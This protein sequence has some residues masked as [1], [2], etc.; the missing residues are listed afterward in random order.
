MTNRH[1]RP[2]RRRPLLPLLAAT[3][4]VALAPLAAQAQA[5][6]GS[7]K[8]ASEARTLPEFHA[9]AQAGSIDL[10]V[11][12][13]GTQQVTVSADDNLL[14]Y[15]ETVVES[16]KDGAMLQIRWKRGTT[17]Y[18]RSRVGVQV[19]V[20]R[21]TALRSAGSGD[22]VVEAFETPALELA[23]SG[24]GDVRLQGLRTDELN[25]RI[26]GSSDVAGSGSAKKLGITIAGSGDVNLGELKADEVKVRIAGSGDAIVHA[27]QTLDVSVAG[28][29][30]VRY[31]GNAKVKSSVAGSG[32][33][34]Q[35]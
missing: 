22:I 23:M 34:R 12:Q 2:I 10:R 32:S 13:G 27:E 31:S 11:R 33:V 9:I 6:T 3:A 14:P 4:L 25:V 20:P 29:G 7:G 5:L 16:G 24:S 18:T 8:I 1:T 19:T 30:D 17:L 35:R 28:S 15:L 21:L 26:S